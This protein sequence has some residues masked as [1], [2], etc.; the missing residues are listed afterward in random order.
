MLAVP[1]CLYAVQNNLLFYALSNLEASVYQVV[2]QL[3][4]L[5][6][7]L[8]SVAL[9]GKSISKQQW[10]ALLILM[11]GII[12]V[13]SPTASTPSSLPASAVGG[14]GS[15]VEAAARPE[16]EAALLGKPHQNPV[17]GLMA[18]LMA[19]CTSGFA[20]VYFEKILKG[21]ANSTSGPQD[22]WI[23]NIQLSVWGG[24]S[25][26][27]LIF[28]NDGAE[29]Q[30]K[31][32][33]TGYAPIVWVVIC[34]QAFGGLCVAMVVKYADNIIKGF[35]G[36]LSIILGTFISVFVFDFELTLKFCLGAFIVIVAVFVYSVPMRALGGKP[37]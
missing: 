32:F 24:L 3:K 22:I 18:V 4:I 23:R 25:S 14:G 36:A 17:L 6:T 19:C 30:A 37:R 33:F 1:A 27:L 11:T 34:N 5:T 8:F 12:L 7:A 29:V 15:A 16:L 35:G 2:Y 26:L 31:G 10:G 28:V 13:Q 9:L 21:S 20:G